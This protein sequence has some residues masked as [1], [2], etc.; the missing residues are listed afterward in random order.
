MIKE[1]EAKEQ[2]PLKTNHNV[3]YNHGAI[4]ILITPARSREEKGRR[5]GAGTPSAVLEFSQQDCHRDQFASF[6]SL[7]IQ[8]ERGHSG[9]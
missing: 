3:S 2:V 1:E 6:G 8:S 9:R 4:A 7:L 5:G